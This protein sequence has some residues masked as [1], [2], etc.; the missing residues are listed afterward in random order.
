[1]GTYDPQDAKKMT[2]QEKCDALEL[3]LFVTEKKDGR[4]K[5]WKC[6]MSSKQHTFD[7]YD[8]LVGSSPTLTTMGL[9]VTSIIDTHE[10]QNVATIDIEPAF[11]HADN[12]KTIIMI[13][14]VKML[15]LLV[16]LKPTMYRKYVTIKNK[17]C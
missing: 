2:K 12:D 5:I 17:N 4:I 7:G 13:M 8:K 1:M 16:Q 3:L 14:Q 11:L 10:G 6:N 15:D 9:I